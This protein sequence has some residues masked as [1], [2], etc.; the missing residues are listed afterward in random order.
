MTGCWR[1]SL[2]P[3]I[4]KDMFIKELIPVTIAVLLLH[5]PLENFIFG[6]GLDNA[7]VTS[8]INVGSC[9]SPLGNRLM[10]AIADALAS[11]KG[12][13]ISD[14]NNRDQPLAVHADILS[15]ILGPQQWTN[16]CRPNDPPWIFDLIIRHIKSSQTVTTHI[17]IPRLAETLPKHVVP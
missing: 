1:E 3:I 6:T 13:I 10:V 16:T 7:G 14:W 2:A 5:I 17:R 4:D 15:K 8:R 9:K 12:Y 11:S